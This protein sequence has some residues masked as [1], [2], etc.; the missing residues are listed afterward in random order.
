MNS[1][2]ATILTLASFRSLFL[3]LVFMLLRA[4]PILDPKTMYPTRLPP[5]PVMSGAEQCEEGWSKDMEQVMR[6]VVV[7]FVASATGGPIVNT[8]SFPRPR[9]SRSCT[10]EGELV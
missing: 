10:A 5:H 7:F 3:F 4:T 2:L 1:G 8:L 9:R 6:L